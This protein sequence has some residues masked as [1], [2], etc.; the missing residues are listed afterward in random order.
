MLVGQRRFRF[1]T[2]PSTPSR[3]RRRFTGSTGLLRS[4]RC[5][6]C[7]GRG[8]ATRAL[9]RG[10]P[11]RTRSM[12]AIDAVVEDAADERLT[13]TKGRSG[14]CLR[15]RSSLA[16]E[17]RVFPHVEEIDAA[18]A[19]ERLSSVSAVSAAAPEL[20]DRALEE[21]RNLVRVGHRALS[22]EYDRCDR[23]P[24]LSSI[25][26]RAASPRPTCT[27]AA[28]RITRLPR[29]RASSSSS[30]CGQGAPCSTSPP[31]GEADA[32]AR[33]AGASVV[34]VEPGDAMRSCSSVSCRRRRRS[35]A[36]RRR[37]RSPMRPSTQS[38]SPGV[39]LVPRG[40]AREIHRVLRPGGAVAL[41][42]NQW[43]EDDP[44]QARIDECSS[45]SPASAAPGGAGRAARARGVA[46][47]RPDRR[48]PVP[49]RR[50][51][52]AEA[53]RMG[54]VDSAVV[55]APPASRRG[56]EARVRVAR[57]RRRRRSDCRHGALLDR[58]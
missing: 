47:L 42:W 7:C 11:R 10:R 46:V 3:W 19:V 40:G 26:Q 52:D 58:A 2:A 29:S 20:R 32:A 36:A 45:R 24:C 13:G 54:L 41:L 50:A 15:R 30:N 38:P 31:D 48:A 37:F 4:R 33:R 8:A 55:T 57:G 25:P 34:A 17:E 35:P 56:V 49:A 27:S 5:T 1:P 51:L 39:P 18:A 12:K 22:D 44:L 14:T 28:G 9:E 53:R 16:L 21:V 6:A 23:A 43:D